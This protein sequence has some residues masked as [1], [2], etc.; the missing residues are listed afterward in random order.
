M[1]KDI[2]MKV[3]FNQ[4]HKTRNAETEAKLCRAN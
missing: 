2:Q 4:Q 1:E 3:V